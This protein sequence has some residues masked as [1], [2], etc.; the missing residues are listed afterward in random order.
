MTALWEQREGRWRLVSPSSYPDEAALHDRVAE[1]PQLL[2]LA[3]SPRVTVLGREVRLGNGYADLIAVERSGRP[4][5]I[6]VKL[7]RNAEARRAVV[8]QVLAYAAYLHGLSL[9]EFE[10]DVLGG[11][12][13]KVGHESVVAAVAAK[14]QSGGVDAAEFEDALSTN[15]RSGRFRLVFVL[16]EAPEELVRLV[17]YLEAMTPELVIDL[18]VVAQYDIGGSQILVPQR[19]DAERR[20]KDS[21]PAPTPTRSDEGVYSSP[22]AGDFAERIEQSPE[23]V[24]G[25]LRRL[26]DWAVTLER[27]RLVSLTTFHGRR[28]LMTLLPRLPVEDVGLVTI[29]FSDDGGY[30]QF[31]RSVFERRAPT[32][33]PLVEAV[34]AP[35]TVGQGTITRD[36]TEELLEALTDAYREANTDITGG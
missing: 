23:G 4:V 19:M 33:L 31:W 28:N 32:A 21:D 7:A 10:R 13:R 1:A 11:H 34:M 14:D 6:E 24:R 15:L 9:T 3:G 12:L 30:F 35:A 2:P 29:W 27:E 16:D 20:E 36:V 8:A 25:Q 17:G 5:V 18:V 22:G 26:H